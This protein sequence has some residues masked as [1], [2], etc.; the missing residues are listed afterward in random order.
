MNLYSSI[1]PMTLSRCCCCCCLCYTQAHLELSLDIPCLLILIGHHTGHGNKIPYL[2]T[3]VIN[4]AV[5][6]IPEDSGSSPAAVYNK[7]VILPGPLLLYKIGIRIPADNLV[8]VLWSL[9]NNEHECAHS[10]TPSC[11][12]MHTFL[13]SEIHF[14]FFI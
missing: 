1:C 5:D 7:L 14:S 13:L 4:R 8:R 3:R 10:L 12:L 2:L 11:A 9:V 6:L